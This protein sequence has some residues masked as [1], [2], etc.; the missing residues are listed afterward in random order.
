MKLECRK[1]CS[2]DPVSKYIAYLASF[3]LGYKAIVKFVA[4]DEGVKISQFI[5]PYHC[6]IHGESCTAYR[7]GESEEAQAVSRDFKKFRRDWK[8]QISQMK[9][10]MAA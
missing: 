1:I 6:R 2:E 5:I 9:K 4:Q 3:G 8:K 7:N 10:E